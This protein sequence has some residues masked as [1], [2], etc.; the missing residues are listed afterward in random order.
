LHGQCDTKRCRVTKQFYDWIT[1]CVE[2]PDEIIIINEEKT[3]LINSASNKSFDSSINTSLIKMENQSFES[4]SPSLE[5]KHQK[6]KFI[7]EGNTQ[8]PFL[9]Q[10][11]LSV[12]TNG[13]DDTTHF[14]KRIDDVFARLTANPCDTP[15]HS[16]KSLIPLNKPEEDNNENEVSLTNNDILQENHD[17]VKKEFGDADHQKGVVDAKKSMDQEIIE[18]LENDLDVSLIN[19]LSQVQSSLEEIEDFTL[20][21]SPP[22]E[23]GELVYQDKKDTSV[24]N[25]VNLKERT[26]KEGELHDVMV[27]SIREHPMIERCDPEENNVIV[28]NVVE[29]R[30]FDSNSENLQGSSKCSTNENECDFIL[31]E[32]TKDKK[33][34]DN[35]IHEEEIVLNESHQNG[36]TC[37]IKD[38]SR[39]SSNSKTSFPLLEDSFETP[40]K[41]NSDANS[42]VF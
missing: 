7:I 33:I 18:F 10:T 24:M 28:T 22:V 36:E 27:D 17:L 2:F 37:D 15:L 26:V 11:G 19:Q 6:D 25:E 42:T 29:N 3:S 35:E 31:S 40:Q 8:N 23:N 32:T 41:D 34:G 38:R 4:I 12:G 5:K 20:H 16:L 39:N 9:S 30:L 21:E 13:I 14:E 1:D